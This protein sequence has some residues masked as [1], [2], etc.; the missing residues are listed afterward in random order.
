[1][2]GWKGRRGGRKGARRKREGEGEGEKRKSSDL[3]QTTKP[4]PVSET[5]ENDN[6]LLG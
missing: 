4:A 1:M 5:G 6:S 2:G 3:G